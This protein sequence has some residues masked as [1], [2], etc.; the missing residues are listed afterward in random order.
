M[1]G[2]IQDILKTLIDIFGRL[3]IL[4][5]Q[6]NIGFPSTNYSKIKNYKFKKA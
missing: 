3:Y 2:D 5:K 6:R 4:V 1:I